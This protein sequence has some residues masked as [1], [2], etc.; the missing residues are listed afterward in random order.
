MDRRTV[1]AFVVIKGTWTR[2]GTADQSTTNPLDV[3]LTIDADLET[4]HAAIEALMKG[5]LASIGFGPPAPEPH[6]DEYDKKIHIFSDFMFKNTELPDYTGVD[7]QVGDDGE[8]HIHVPRQHRD[9]REPWCR[10]CRLN[11]NCQEPAG[12]FSHHDKDQGP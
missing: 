6:D 12:G 9:K 10:T 8:R 7:I 11:K 2:V 4:S 3:K 1:P 5:K